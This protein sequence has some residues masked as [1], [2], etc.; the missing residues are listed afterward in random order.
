MCEN[1]L[2]SDV[3]CTITRAKWP[4]PW[5]TRFIIAPA[6]KRDVNNKWPLLF[7]NFECRWHKH[8]GLRRI[9][10]GPWPVELNPSVVQSPE[11]F[12]NEPV[13]TWSF[14]RTTTACRQYRPRKHSA[15]SKAEEQK[16]PLTTQSKG[17]HSNAI[18]QH[19]P[20]QSNIA[21][22]GFLCSGFVPSIWLARLAKPWNCITEQPCRLFFG[23]HFS[24]VRFFNHGIENASA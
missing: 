20:T 7:S 13:R 1:T 10:V 16:M 5:S 18:K 12:E 6:P 4:L 9:I 8:S 22:G 21:W 11:H 17:L 15:M 24:F 3:P 14:L 23:I 19:V 2:F